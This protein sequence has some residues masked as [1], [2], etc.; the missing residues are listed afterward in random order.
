[1]KFIFNV[2]LLTLVLSLL[3][4][5]CNKNVTPKL[6][7]EHDPVVKIIEERDSMVVFPTDTNK[8]KQSKTN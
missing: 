2:L 3:F 4:T 7:E 1:M 6:I 5:A 8:I